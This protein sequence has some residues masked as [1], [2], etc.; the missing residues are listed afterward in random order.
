MCEGL[1]RAGAELSD[2][3]QVRSWLTDRHDI[4]AYVK[5]RKDVISHRPAYVLV[6]V[7]QLIRPSLRLE[8]EATAVVMQ[9]AAE[10][11]GE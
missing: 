5:V 8:I 10:Q 1:R 7:P 6:L 3:G 11:Q 2:I 4:D 9:S